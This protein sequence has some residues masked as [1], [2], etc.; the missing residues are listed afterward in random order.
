VT[1]GSAVRRPGHRR[2]LAA[3]A[4]LA[5]GAGV[6]AGCT[7]DG[8]KDDKDP[9]SSA[10]AGTAT[11]GAGNALSAEA[12]RIT[13]QYLNGTAPTVLASVA[14]KVR[15][16]SGKDVPG[17]LDL[18]AVQAGPRST[19]VRWRLSTD[20]PIGTVSTNYYNYL[21]NRLPDTDAVALL[22]EEANLRMLPG[23]WSGTGLSSKDCTCAYVP[24]KVGPE[25]VELSS[26]YPPLPTSVTRIQLQVPGFPA[27]AAPVTRS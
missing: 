13:A 21:Y 12:A 15:D 27:L 23:I 1:I 16:G 7:G 8:D 6:L 11:T 17:K 18:L 4:I 25:G 3:L 2:S 19:A 24:G 9:T 10:S 26:L 22:A 20:D 5:L 14:G